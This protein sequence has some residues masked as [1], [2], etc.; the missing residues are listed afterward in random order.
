MPMK[1][2]NTGFGLRLRELRESKGLTQAQLADA[3]GIRTSGVTK[4]E[5]GISEPHWPTVLSLA[6]ALG[7]D[8]N[9]F[10][11]ASAAKPRGRGRPPKAEAPARPKRRKG[12]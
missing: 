8:C 6:E 3:A 10:Q 4:L 2:A 7:V 12:E 9:E 5:Q 1:K 11:E